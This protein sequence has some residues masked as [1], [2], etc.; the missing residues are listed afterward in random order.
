MIIIIAA[1]VITSCKKG[2]EDPFLSLKSRKA[3]L[4]GEWKLVS[5]TEVTNSNGIVEQIIYSGTTATQT[6]GQVETN[7]VYLETVSFEKTNEF[8][9]EVIHD[10]D[11]EIAEGFWAFMNGHDEIANKECV[12]VRIAKIINGSNVTMYSRDY[13]PLEIIRLLKLSSKEVILE[14]KGTEA[15]D[16]KTWS[17]TST[18]TYEK[19]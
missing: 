9:M 16:G 15:W 10:G 18:M 1:P 4:V 2:E 7:Y 5:G 12:V 3:R 19:M 14:S 13:M 8:K 6:V 11:I 17:F